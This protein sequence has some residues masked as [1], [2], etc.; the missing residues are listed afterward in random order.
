MLL[1]TFFVDYF[2]YFFEYQKLFCKKIN[3]FFQLFV[4]IFLSSTFM[5]IHTIFPINKQGKG[6]ERIELFMIDLKR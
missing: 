5:S 1:Y 6:V 3:V 2:K 4:T